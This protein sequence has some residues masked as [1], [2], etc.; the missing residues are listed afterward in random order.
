MHIDL[1]LV[2][3]LSTRINEVN[4]IIVVLISSC[5][6]RI[7]IVIEVNVE[8]ESSKTQGFLIRKDILML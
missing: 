4:V 8:F 2:K 1:S 5:I 3:E 7:K 6:G